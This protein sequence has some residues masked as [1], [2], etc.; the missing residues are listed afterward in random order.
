MGKGTSLE[1]NILA[2]QGFLGLQNSYGL[3]KFFATWPQFFYDCTVPYLGLIPI[4]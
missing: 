1:R 4:D 2:F 3:P